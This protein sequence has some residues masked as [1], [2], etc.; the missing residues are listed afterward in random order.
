MAGRWARLAVVVV[1]WWVLIAVAVSPM[2]PSPVVSFATGALLLMPGHHA[3]IAQRGIRDW[4]IPTSRAAFD[5]FQR[6]FAEDDE[7][8]MD[9]AFRSAEWVAVNYGDLVRVLAVDGEVVGIELLEGAYAG[10]RA[11][12]K[13]RQLAPWD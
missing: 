9:G 8:A 12:L 2:L 13:Q 3:R 6:G 10:R 1:A 5:E 11:W 7:D 4:P